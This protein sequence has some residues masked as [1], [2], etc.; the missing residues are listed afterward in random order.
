MIKRLLLG[1]QLDVRVCN[2]VARGC[3]FT[4]SVLMPT[5]DVI[6]NV[7]PQAVM[8]TIHCM[9]YIAGSSTFQFEKSADDVGMA[10]GATIHT[11]NGLKVR[12]A[13]RETAVACRCRLGAEPVAASRVGACLR[14]LR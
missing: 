14:Q 1:T 8:P 5:L 11:A 4:S 6:C 9:L 2:D 13:R 3:H 7:Q 10:S 12:V